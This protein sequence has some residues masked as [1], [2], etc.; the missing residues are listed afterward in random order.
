VDDG[1]RIASD[2]SSNQQD[3]LDSCADRGKT[4]Q[5]IRKSATGRNQD[6]DDRDIGHTDEDNS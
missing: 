4:G 2:Q 6:S 5:E 1:F 3:Q